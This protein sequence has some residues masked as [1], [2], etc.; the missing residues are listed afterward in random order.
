M[1]AATISTAVNTLR[2]RGPPFDSAAM[3]W[4]HPWKHGFLL[5]RKRGCRAVGQPGLNDRMCAER[6]VSCSLVNSWYNCFLKTSVVQEK[7]EKLSCK[8]YWMF[9]SLVVSEASEGK[10]GA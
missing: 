2:C 10:Q 4:G 9:Y 1:L 3:V 7:L 8:L 5:C 6:C